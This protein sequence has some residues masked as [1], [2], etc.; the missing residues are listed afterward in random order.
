M[1]T[2]LA[3]AEKEQGTGSTNHTNGDGLVDD[4]GDCHSV[5]NDEDGRVVGHFFGAIT[6]VVLTVVLWSRREHLDKMWFGH[7]NEDTAKDREDQHLLL[8]SP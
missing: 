1:M 8:A 2:C 3:E 6:T 5:L 4:D 7:A